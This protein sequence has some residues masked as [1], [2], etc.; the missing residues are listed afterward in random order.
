MAACSFRPLGCHYSF[1]R[2][3]VAV[4]H[5]VYSGSGPGATPVVEATDGVKV[6]APVS[7][8]QRQYLQN[9]PQL[10]TAPIQHLQLN[11]SL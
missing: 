5:S 6:R 1:D 2:K 4:S 10:I 11:F 3:E 9:T 7:L 8:Q